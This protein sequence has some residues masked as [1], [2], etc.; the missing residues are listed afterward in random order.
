MV[1]P[2]ASEPKGASCLADVA[3]RWAV[4][5]SRCPA[6]FETTVVVEHFM[7]IPLGASESPL[8]FGKPFSAIQYTIGY[9]DDWERIIVEPYLAE[10]EDREEGSHVATIRQWQNN[11]WMQRDDE[12]D[13]VRIRGR[14]PTNLDHDCFA[15]FNV[16]DGPSLGTAMSL[17]EVLNSLPIVEQ[18]SDGQRCRIIF[19][20]GADGRH[21]IA[22]EFDLH[23]SCRLSAVTSDVV[24]PEGE[25]HAGEV[26]SRVHY[27]VV[28]WAEFDGMV[29]PSV[30]YRDGYLFYSRV[31][32][33]LNGFEP[34]VSR[35]VI[36]RT[37]ASQRISERLYSAA[38]R[39]LPGD[40]VHDER[41]DLRYIYGADV[42]TVSGFGV[43]LQE[44]IRSDLLPQ[45]A[46][47]VT[48]QDPQ[49]VERLSEIPG[50]AAPL[51]R[52]VYWSTLTGVIAFAAV[53]LLFGVR[54]YRGVR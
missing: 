10:S 45:L 42:A 54:T 6:K 35:T 38:I 23:P 36:R 1:L 41:A 51:T 32:E 17:T 28:E 5:Q 16:V 50:Y 4:L 46:D 20:N 21:R 3:N 25:A 11:K 29:L 47:M 9:T 30:A 27:H 49:P 40:R 22:F 33:A 44:P 13:S 48:S 19:A 15:F 53:M 34:T 8:V 14:R 43:R 24:I 39:I 18:R 31:R 12:A 37:S 52:R 2:P 7:A 26:K